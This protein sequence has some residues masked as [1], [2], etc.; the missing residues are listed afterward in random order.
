M[1]ATQGYIDGSSINQAPVVGVD[2]GLDHFMLKIGF[3]SSVTPN[4]QG[5]EQWGIPGAALTTLNHP[6]RDLRP[7]KNRRKLSGLMSIAPLSHL[8]APAKTLLGVIRSGMVSKALPLFRGMNPA[9]TI[10]DQVVVSCQDPFEDLD[11]QG[12]LKLL[13]SVDNLIQ[14]GFASCQVKPKC[15]MYFLFHRG[16][17]PLVSV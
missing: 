11:H 5:M 1:N 2:H 16:L 12:V 15:Y 13:Q 14:C 4:L 17:V 6:Q 7:A 9:Q 8:S 3:L 10:T